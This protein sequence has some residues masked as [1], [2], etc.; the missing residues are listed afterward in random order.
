MDL[1]NSRQSSQVHH[2]DKVCTPTG[3]LQSSAGFWKQIP[4]LLR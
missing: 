3:V 2:S 1:E 4:K